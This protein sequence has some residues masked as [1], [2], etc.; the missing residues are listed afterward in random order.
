MDLFV[1]CS[2]GL[3]PLLI[4]ELSELGIEASHGF[5]GVYVKDWTLETIYRLNY[6]S[7]IASR[8]LF[9]ISRFT[10]RGREDLY[11]E[12]MQI[13][14]SRA[15]VTNGDITKTFAIDANVSS[16]E[17]HHSLFAAQ[18]LKDA[19]CDQLRQKV[20]KRPNVDVKDPDIQ[21]NLFV[22]ND[23]GV[24]SFDTSGK[25][26]HQRGYRQ[27]SVE[28]PIQENLAA[29]VLRMAKLADTDVVFDPCCGS[30]TFLIEAAMILSKTPAGYFRKNW[31]FFNLPSFDEKLWW[32]VKEKA[33]QQIQTL[34]AGK[35]SGIDIMKNCV[36]STRVNIRAA[37]MHRF[38][39]VDCADFRD[40]EPTVVPTFLIAN[41]PWGLRLDE[42]S[43]L[44][45]LYR[46]LGDFMKQKMHKPGRGF[47]LTGSPELAKEVGLAADHRHIVYNGGIESRL[48]EF[49]IY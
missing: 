13:D 44:S 10:C 33:D 22:H 12:A 21:L 3:E 7:R 40:Y 20:N 16:E 9:P 24:I 15:F 5:R 18:V 23:V 29:A 26:L 42:V 36:H 11:K 4:E 49:D 38:V 47:I 8:V 34:P 35:I 32:S 48:L 46:A 1:T 19:I 41:P 45:P 27:E 39:S 17:M 6:L 14:W 43:R 25:P 30:G 2:Q 28:A 37:G 31:G